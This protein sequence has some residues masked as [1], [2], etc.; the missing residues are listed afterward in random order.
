MRAGYARMKRPGRL[1]DSDYSET[2]LEKKNSPSFKNLITTI[3]NKCNLI[4]Q[5]PYSACKSERLKWNYRGKRSG[6]INDQ[7]R[8][9]YMICEECIKQNDYDYNHTDCPDCQRVALKRVRFID[10]TDYH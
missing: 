6:R 7:Y 10:I 5:A 9:E 4:L 8:V 2:F 1:Y 3:E